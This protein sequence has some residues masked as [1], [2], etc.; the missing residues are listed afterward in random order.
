MELIVIKIVIL[1]SAEAKPT[2]HKFDFKWLKKCFF[3][4][5]RNEIS[6]CWKRKWKLLAI[7][8]I[9]RRVLSVSW[10]ALTFKCAH[11]IDA[12]RIVRTISTC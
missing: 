1:N 10:V 8:S 5:K 3:N 4:D 7:T 12:L 11:Y 6:V 9:I 2:A